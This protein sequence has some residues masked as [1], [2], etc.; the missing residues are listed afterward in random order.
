MGRLV[1]GGALAC[2][3]LVAACNMLSGA[4]SLTAGSDPLEQPQTSAPPPPSG[5]IG[6]SGVDSGASAR[7][8]DPATD[9]GVT[10]LPP[11]EAGIDAASG[12][13][14]ALPTFIDAF[15]RT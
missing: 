15:G 5:S 1:L 13:A 8:H 6:S 4:D 3:A 10:T 2:A 14:A 9:A 12:A 11:D 7:P